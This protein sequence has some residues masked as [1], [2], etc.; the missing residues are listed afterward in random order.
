MDKFINMKGLE[1]I[2]KPFMFCVLSVVA[3]LTASCATS[4]ATSQ[5]EDEDTLEGYNRAVFKFN[6]K[7]DKYIM[8]PIAEGYR[9]I[10]TESVRNRI[11][12]VLSNV[13]EPLFA[14]N[15]LLQ[16]DV[17]QSGIELGRFVINTTLGLGGMFDVAEGW[18][19]PKK[20]TNID[21]TLAKWCVPDG[22][23]FMLPF[24]GPSTPRAAT[25]LALEVVFDPVY[26]AT[27]NDANIR[28][29]VTYSY[30][31][32]QVISL[33]EQNLEL[34]DELERGSVDFYSTMRSAYM[35]NRKNMG[36]Q[37]S[38]SDAQT[39]DFDFGLEEEDEAFNE[40][41]AEQ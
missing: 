31:A 3:G 1:V 19:L 38:G 4:T 30:L 2:K 22:P 7:F 25:S 9:D 20:R 28:D 16:G 37:K 40:M 39:Y 17:K 36:C 5:H 29:K 15:H 32:L 18:G 14:G 10:T 23:F 34:L 13:R 33:R 26:W 21:Q 35:Q 24:I 8:K 12:G 6:D 11:R 41:D 27:Y